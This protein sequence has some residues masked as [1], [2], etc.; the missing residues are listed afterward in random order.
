MHY[1]LGFTFSRWKRLHPFS[2]TGGQRESTNSEV[3]DK[4]A[5]GDGSLFLLGALRG[6]C[7]CPTADSTQRLRWALPRS[8]YQGHRCAPPA[9]PG[10]ALGDIERRRATW[11]PQRDLW[12]PRGLSSKLEGVCSRLSQ[13]LDWIFLC[14]TSYLCDISRSVFLS[15][16]T[17]C[18]GLLLSKGEELNTLQIIQQDIMNIMQNKFTDYINCK[19]K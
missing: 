19:Q 12:A 6:G 16:K 10:P 8:S 7:T 13:R 4:G 3:R 2:H 17:G 5:P 9:R 14:T 1:N 18:R 11:Y 15:P